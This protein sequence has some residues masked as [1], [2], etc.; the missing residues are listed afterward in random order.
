MQD[1]DKNK[2]KKLKKAPKAMYKSQMLNILEQLQVLYPDVSR[3]EL[4]NAVQDRLE[5]KFPELK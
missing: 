2:R 4:W 5:T 1:F 3:S